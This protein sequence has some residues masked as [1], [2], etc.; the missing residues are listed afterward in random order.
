MLQMKLVLVH[1]LADTVLVVD[2]GRGYCS[3]IWVSQAFGG[4][5]QNIE[6]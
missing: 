4:V 5:Q 1:C 6:A 3:I 2:K